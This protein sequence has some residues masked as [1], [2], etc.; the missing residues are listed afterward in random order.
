MNHHLA[1][2]KQD[3]EYET[4]PDTLD[5]M[6]ALAHPTGVVWDP[7]FC[8]GRSAD[9]LRAQGHTV[10][11]EDRDFFD[12][13]TR[14]PASAYDCVLTNPPFSRLREAVRDVFDLGVKAVVL[15]PLD[16]LSRVWMRDYLPHAQVVI[17][18][19]RINFIKDG[20]LTR[21]C[22]FNTVFLCLGC[23]LPRD[24]SVAK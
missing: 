21:R 10:L 12:T 2:L 4:P 13:A 14:P 23:G 6:A 16:A 3:D 22:S 5:T 17:P 9:H 11:H 18:R 20:V 24:I 8:H 15:V 1:K 19:R 7:F